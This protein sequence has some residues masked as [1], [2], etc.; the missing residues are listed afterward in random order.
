MKDISTF[1][2]LLQIE[3]NGEYRL[4][5]DIDCKNAEISKVIDCFK[6]IIEGEGHVIRNL[7]LVV[8]KIWSD[9]QPVALFYKMKRARI[10]NLRIM[11]L[12][13]DIPKSVYSFEV[14]ALCVKASDTLFENVYVEATSTCSGK[15]PFVYDSNNC[16]YVNVQLSDNMILNKFD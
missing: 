6:G 3:P 10:K 11:N 4:T 12:K 14:A 9:G 1:D 15:L 5:C 8:D 7:S 2:E 13:I 16:E